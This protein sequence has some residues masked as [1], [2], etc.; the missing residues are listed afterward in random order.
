MTVRMMQ[1]E[2]QEQLQAAQE[3]IRSN[4]SL[5]IGNNQLYCLSGLGRGSILGRQLANSLLGKVR[6]VV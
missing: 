5:E 1:I 4:S 2:C 3:E 6:R